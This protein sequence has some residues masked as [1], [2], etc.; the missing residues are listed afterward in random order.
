MSFSLDPELDFGDDLF[1]FASFDTPVVAI[2]NDEELPSSPSI[3]RK[4]DDNPSGRS[5]SVP[6]EMICSVCGAPAH[7]YNFDRVTC[8]SC[9]AFFRRNAL[10]DTVRP[11]RFSFFSTWTVSS[12]AGRVE[13]RA[14][15]P[16]PWQRD[17]NVLSVG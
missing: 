4:S 2:Q 16:S 10:R 9:K 15:V 5:S 6:F 13:T 3:F 12:R 14:R 1:L 11:R 7:G 8:E 17:V